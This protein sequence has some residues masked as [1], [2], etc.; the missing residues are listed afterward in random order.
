MKRKLLIGLTG[1]LALGGGGVGWLWNDYQRFVSA[2]LPLS[3]QGE[4]FT[5]V[6]GTSFSE[7]Q[8]ALS[9]NGWIDN[10]HYFRLLARESGLGRRL[11]AGEYEVPVGTTPLSLLQIL[12]SGRS[13]QHRVTLVEGS[14]FSELKAQLLSDSRLTHLLTNMDNK[15]LLAELK[16]DWKHPE[17]LFLAETYQ[18]QRGDS[19]LS[20]LLRAHRLLKEKLNAA[21]QQRTDKKSYKVPYEALI[22]AS[23][24]E[25]ETAQPRERPQIAGVFA[26]R[27]SKGMRL[28][29]DPTVI[30]GMGDRYVGNITRADLRRPTPYNTYV[31]KGLPPTPIATVGVEAIEAA[32]NPAEGKALYF[33]ARGDGSHVFSNTLRQH[34][35]AVREYQLRRRKD[36]RSTPE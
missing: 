13:I 20:I 17:G 23:I 19:D 1:V 14:R 22:M 21:W 16:T 10:K 25:K 12:A 29:T 32:L 11:K 31:I 6:R 28:Q 30:Y 24:I 9:R 2:S 33:V 5:L 18:F 34:N 7:L 4:V 36:Y 15:A 3:G 26:R 27:L 8:Q 35:R